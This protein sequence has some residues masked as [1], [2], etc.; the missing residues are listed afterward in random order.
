[1]RLMSSYTL[2]NP[3]ND[4]RF[5]REAVSSAI[6]VFDLA[7]FGINPDDFVFEMIDGFV[8]LP[9]DMYDVAYKIEGIIKENYMEEFSQNFEGW[10]KIWSEIKN[11]ADDKQRMMRFWRARLSNFS[12]VEEILDGIR[13]HRQ[14]SCYEFSVFKDFSQRNWKIIPIG[15][16]IF[17]QKVSDGRSRNRVFPITKEKVIANHNLHLLIV[18]LGQYLLNNANIGAHQFNFTFHQM[19]THALG[20]GYNN[21]A[22]EG[23]HQ[24]GASFI[25]SALVIERVNVRG[26]VSSVFYNKPQLEGGKVDVSNLEKSKIALE[27]EL[28]VGEG[29][30]QAD[31]FSDL[32][33]G[34]SKVTRINPDE[35]GYRS[36][37]GFDIELIK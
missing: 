25:M 19:K 18:S 16:P 26:G 15:R 36:I 17:S 31:E 23:I 20:S 12:K 21:P 32:W 3:A 24:D 14:R 10:M 30:F 13:P 35:K 27:H 1:M 22:P 2:P 28:E 6:K 29:L 33:H 8:D 9:F 4:Y 37:I 11:Q 7:E 5:R 34:I